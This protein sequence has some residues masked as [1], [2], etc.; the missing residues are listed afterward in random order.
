LGKTN[1]PEAWSK[2]LRTQHDMI[3]IYANSLNSVIFNKIYCGSWWRSL[4]VIFLT[5]SKAADIVAGIICSSA[6]TLVI[7]E[8]PDRW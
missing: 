8:K 5:S 3:Y 6:S 7:A 4:E 2:G 1:S